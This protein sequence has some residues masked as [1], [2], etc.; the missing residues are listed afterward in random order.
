MLTLLARGES[1]SHRS[2]SEGALISCDY[3]NSVF[4][5]DQEDLRLLLPKSRSLYELCGKNCVSS[6]I[7]DDDTSLGAK[8]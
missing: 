2:D 5:L 3:L 7:Y 4:S 1:F 8:V 6:D